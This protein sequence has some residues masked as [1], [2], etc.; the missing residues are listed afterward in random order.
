M[1][2]CNLIIEVRFQPKNLLIPVILL[3]EPSAEDL[4]H[5]SKILVDDLI[6]LYKDGVRIITRTMPDGAC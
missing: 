5:Y 1:Q 3:G 6:K 4:Q 2:S